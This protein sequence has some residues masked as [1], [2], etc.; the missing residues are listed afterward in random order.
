MKQQV[1]ST[2]MMLS[3]EP[4]LP[5]MLLQARRSCTT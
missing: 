2:V 5:T 4:W 1:T 3:E